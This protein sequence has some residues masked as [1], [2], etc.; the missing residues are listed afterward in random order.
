MF[1]PVLKGEHVTLRPADDGD[2]PR[3]LPWLADLEVT[4][5][6]GRRTGVALYQ[7]VDF[8]K[9]AGEDKNSV[10]WVIEHDGETVGATGIHAIDWL[11]AHGTTGILIGA[12]EKWG[13]GIA[14]EAMRL[15]TRYAFREL[16]L[17]KLSTEVFVP[18]EASKRALEKNGYRTV[19]IR[20]RHFFA[21]GKWHDIWIGEVLREDWDRA[22]PNG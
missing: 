3:F 19:G 4:R 12:K 9:K 15:R 6:L 13:K 5:F 11:S 14:T 21:G 18:N 17:Q 16:N 1:G 2:P 22:H 10:L 7:E 8:L 20:R